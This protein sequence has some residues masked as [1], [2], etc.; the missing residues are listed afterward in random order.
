[1]TGVAFYGWLFP[2]RSINF[3]CCYVGF[4]ALRFKL[5]AIYMM[6]IWF[7]QGITWNAYVVLVCLLSA[8]LISSLSHP[9]LGEQCL[10]RFEHHDLNDW[11][12]IMCVFLLELTAHVGVC[13]G[14]SVSFD[15][16]VQLGRRHRAG[17]G[18]GLCLLMSNVS[19]CCRM[20]SFVRCVVEARVFGLFHSE[21][22][23]GQ[24]IVAISRLKHINRTV[25]F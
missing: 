12:D 8:W 14:F 4:C 15:P 6:C 11:P 22:Q 19:L 9:S 16:R 24:T 1:M 20:P 17:C 2:V 10:L 18:K 13:G 21:F 3:V 23:A 25:S 5:A 7:C